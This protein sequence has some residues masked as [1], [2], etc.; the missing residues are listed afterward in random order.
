MTRREQLWENYEEALFA[1]FMDRVAED[2]GRRLLEENERLKQDPAAAVPRE[3]DRR[4][5]AAIRRAFARERRNRAAARSWRV[6][7]RVCV[8]AV[9]AAILLAT[10]FAAFPQFRSRTLN[11]LIQIGDMAA[12]LKMSGEGGGEPA[13]ELLFGYALPDLPEGF[14]ETYRSENEQSISL[15]F[16]NQDGAYICFSLQKEFGGGKYNVDAEDAQRVEPISIHGFDGLLI[17]K[18]GTIY[19][20]WGDTDRSIYISLYGTGIDRDALL[21]LAKGLH[22][23]IPA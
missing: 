3:T 20:S 21:T 13:R 23:E 8:A 5:R 11:L 2:E 14:T 12:T 1:L 19:I 15:K 4:C 7:R 18:N 10:A 16:E 6:L 9:L 17:K 22:S